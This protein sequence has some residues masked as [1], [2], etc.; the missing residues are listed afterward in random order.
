MEDDR[1]GNRSGGVS[2]NSDGHSF[3]VRARGGRNGSA[4]LYRTGQSILESRLESTDGFASGNDLPLFA[5]A[6]RGLASAGVGGGIG[7]A[8]TNSGHQYR[9]PRDSGAW[10]RGSEVVNYACFCEAGRVRKHH[11]TEDGTSEPRKCGGAAD[12]HENQEREFF[13][14]R[15]ASDVLHPHGRDG[16]KDG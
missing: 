6:L 15:Q 7:V 12:G 8:R 3:S 10:Q 9:G 13:L 5:F 2:R 4:A 11:A 14:R 16:G 1:D